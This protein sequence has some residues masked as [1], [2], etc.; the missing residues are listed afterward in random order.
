[1]F[2]KKRISKFKFMRLKL[3]ILLI[4][5]FAGCKNNKTTS[6]SLPFFNAASLTPHWI[7]KGAPEYKRIHNIADFKLVNQDGDTITNANYKGKIYVADFFFT[8]C[9]GIC[10]I[11]EKHMSILQEEYEFDPQ[12]LLLSHTVMPSRDSVSVLKKYAEKNEIKASK[13][14]L[15]TGKKKDIYNLARYSY[16]ADEDFEKTQD[17]NAFIHTENFILIDQLGRIRGV[18]NGTLKTDLKRLIRHIE[19]LKKE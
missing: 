8:I 2:I 11:L 13:W 9:P 7:E 17:E 1:M 19:I 16:F 15:V 6:V 18:Y 14:N 10:P 12:V 4:I 3:F 5:L